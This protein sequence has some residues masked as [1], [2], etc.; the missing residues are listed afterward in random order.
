VA[1]AYGGR[2]L[3]E[4]GASGGAGVELRLPLAAA[5]APQA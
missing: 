4:R 3:L 5:A 1:L 2:L